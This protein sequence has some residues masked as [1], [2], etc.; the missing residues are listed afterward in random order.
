MTEETRQKILK[1]HA[2]GYSLREIGLRVGIRWTY[3]LR[4]VIHRKAMLEKA[5]EK[6]RVEQKPMRVCRRCKRPGHYAKT[7]EVQV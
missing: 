6:R 3:S 7:C 1:L 5:A 4:W 2:E